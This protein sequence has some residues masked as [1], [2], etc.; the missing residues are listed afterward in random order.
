[1]LYR[2]LVI[3]YYVAVAYIMLMVLGGKNLYDTILY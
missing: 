2:R 3:V 1:M